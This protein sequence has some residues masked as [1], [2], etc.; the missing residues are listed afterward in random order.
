[1]SH[2]RVEIIFEQYFVMGF[3]LIVKGIGYKKKDRCKKIQ[4]Q[5]CQIN[6]CRMEWLTKLVD[7]SGN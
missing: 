6:L 2:E 1:M 4:Q 5:K 3:G 7:F